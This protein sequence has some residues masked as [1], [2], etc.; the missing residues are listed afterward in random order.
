MTMALGQLVN[1]TSIGTIHA[2]IAR[3]HTAA[4]SG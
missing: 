3:G 4:S 1:D 2:L